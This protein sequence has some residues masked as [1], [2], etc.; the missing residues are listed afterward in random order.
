MFEIPRIWQPCQKAPRWWRQPDY[1][2]QVEFIFME[3]LNS[4][5]GPMC[6]GAYPTVYNVHAEYLS[7]SKLGSFQSVILVSTFNI[8]AGLLNYSGC[9]YFD[10]ELQTFCRLLRKVQLNPHNE[11]VTVTLRYKRIAEWSKSCS[12]WLLDGATGQTMPN[13]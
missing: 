3:N 11:G 12:T 1:L 8:C 13:Y 4:I 7:L 10:F 6:I 9:Q 2:C 5:S